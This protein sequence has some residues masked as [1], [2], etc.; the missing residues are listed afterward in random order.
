MANQS[1]SLP[2]ETSDFASGFVAAPE[3]EARTQRAVNHPYLRVL[4]NGVFLDPRGAV[5]DATAVNRDSL[6]PIPIHRE[7]ASLT[8][9]QVCASAPAAA[10]SASRGDAV[11]SV[12]VPAVSVSFGIGVLASERKTSNH[13]HAYASRLH[14][15]AGEGSEHAPFDSD[16]FAALAA[17]VTNGFVRGRAAPNDRAYPRINPMNAVIATNERRQHAHEIPE[18]RLIRMVTNI[19]QS[20]SIE[21]AF[22]RTCILTGDDFSSENVGRYRDN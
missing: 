14:I 19:A 3:A 1:L 7:G 13:R 2:S 22:E 11:F 6:T 16:A 21:R 8:H 15:L 9:R 4:E 17:I 12:D 18:W 20:N 10:F 5:F